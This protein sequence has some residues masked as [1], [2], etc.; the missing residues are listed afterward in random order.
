MPFN[1]KYT[2]RVEMAALKCT[3]RFFCRFIF[4]YIIN[5]HEWASSSV[6]LLV[7][8]Y[9]CYLKWE[10]NKKPISMGLNCV[11]AQIEYFVSAKLL[12]EP[13]YAAAYKLINHIGDGINGC[14][15]NRLYVFRGGGEN[16]KYSTL[17]S[18]RRYTCKC[19]L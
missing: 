8:I 11:G 4:I 1:N 16:A 3:Y 14:E 9:F 6:V 12:S 13:E 17:S 2:S 15:T 18:V 10:S 19:V 7:A 5:M